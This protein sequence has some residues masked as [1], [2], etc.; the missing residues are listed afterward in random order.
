MNALARHFG[1][2]NAKLVIHLLLIMGWVF[3]LRLVCSVY[4]LGKLSIKIFAPEFLWAFLYY[5]KLLKIFCVK[6]CITGNF[7]VALC[8]GRITLTITHSIINIVVPE[9]ITSRKGK[10]LMLLSKYRYMMKH[11]KYVNGTN[12]R[13]VCS[14]RAN[15]SCKA[16]VWT[17]D[18]KV[19]KGKFEHTHPPIQ[20]KTEQ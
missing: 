5:K 11:G 19:H 3:F 7:H 18:R 16:V 15:K 13:W 20:I 10:P 9:F 1:F 14:S 17:C 6:F 4:E 2:Y 8:W 12:T